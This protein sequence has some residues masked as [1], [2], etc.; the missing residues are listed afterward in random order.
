MKQFRQDLKLSVRYDDSIKVE[1]ISQTFSDTYRLLLKSSSGSQMSTMLVNLLFTTKHHE[2]VWNQKTDR[3]RP[4]FLAVNDAMV[5]L[6]INQNKSMSNLH[7]SRA[8]ALEYYREKP[9]ILSNSDGY[10]KPPVTKQ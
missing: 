5:I 3:N 4:L 7:G 8:I 9:G 6:F 2:S 10:C 1:G